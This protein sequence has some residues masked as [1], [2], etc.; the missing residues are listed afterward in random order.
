MNLALPTPEALRQ[1]ATTRLTLAAMIASAFLA[2]LIFSTVWL[3]FDA[4]ADSADEGNGP[5]G[6]TVALLIATTLA[7]IPAACL[8]GVAMH[9]GAKRRSQAS[10][11]GWAMVGGG[12][13]L[14]ASMLCIVLASLDGLPDSWFILIVMGVVFLITVIGAIVSAPMGIAFGALFLIALHPMTLR[15]DD[16][17]IDTPASAMRT[18]ALM[19]LVA[20][21]VATLFAAAIH[22]PVATFAHNHLALDCAWIAVGVLP[23]PLALSTLE[24]S[25]QLSG[26]GKWVGSRLRFEGEA[27]AAPEHE[28]ALA[29]LL[30][31]IGR[32]SGARSII[33]L[34]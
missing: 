6:I 2:P 27:R 5:F 23:A 19:L 24:G 9:R 7:I 3:G 31:I 13:F 34:G 11:V 17:S 26:N 20:T 16:P 33:T 29:N 30:N 25:L 28:A 32:R 8:G 10:A 12:L 21:G 22:V 18:S 15:L 14:G 1:R 4:M